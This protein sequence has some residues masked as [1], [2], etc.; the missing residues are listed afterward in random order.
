MLSSPQLTAN[1]I[2]LPLSTKTSRGF[3]SFTKTYR[4]ETRPCFIWQRKRA[5]A[6]LGFHTLTFTQKKNGALRYI[7]AHLPLSINR[8]DYYLRIRDI[9]MLGML[10]CVLA[11]P[12]LPEPFKP[13]K[14]DFKPDVIASSKP[15]TYGSS[16]SQVTDTPYQVSGSW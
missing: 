9:Q 11:H 12:S 15:L 8:M 2:L 13:P 16:S 4:S 3:L 14:V 7:A 5:H 6:H 10:A 1:S